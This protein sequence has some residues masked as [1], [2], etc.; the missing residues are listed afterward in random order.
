MADKNTINTTSKTK[1]SNMG[2]N[3]TNEKEKYS[4][5]Q[6]ATNT[7]DKKY[8][9]KCTEIVDSIAR[10]I[11]AAQ[12]FHQVCLRPIESKKVLSD[13]I[14]YKISDKEF[15]YAQSLIKK[16]KEKPESSIE[17]TYK[18]YLEKIYMSKGLNINSDSEYVFKIIRDE[19]SLCLINE[20]I[21]QYENGLNTDV[22]KLSKQ[23]LIKIIGIR[24]RRI[25]E[26]RCYTYSALSRQTGISVAYLNKIEKGNIKKFLCH[27]KMYTLKNFFDCSWD[28]LFGLN[29]FYKGVGNY[30]DFSNTITL[31]PTK[32]IYNYDLVD[33]FY[34]VI[35]QDDYDSTDLEEYLKKQLSLE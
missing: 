6:N 8:N 17:I 16:L 10:Y 13:V 28:Y 11:L 19:T 9:N 23:V 4:N 33:L 5:G 2:Y 26:E 12:R 21:E 32:H 7:S 15:C 22:G 35:T 3:I 18:D 27:K 20:A 1:N 31:N 14:R 34:Q 29:Q 30:L 25:R 24:I